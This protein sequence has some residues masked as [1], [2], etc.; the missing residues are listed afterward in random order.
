MTAVHASLCAPQVRSKTIPS[1][2][3]GVADFAKRGENAIPLG[4]SMSLDGVESV[5]ISA[6]LD[7]S[8]TSNCGI[9]GRSRNTQ[10]LSSQLH[11]LLN[12]VSRQ[13]SSPRYGSWDSSQL[14]F[15]KGEI[16]RPL[17]AVGLTLHLT[18]SLALSS[19]CHRYRLSCS[20]SSNRHAA[21]ITATAEGLPLDL[22]LVNVTLFDL[23][24]N[25]RSELGHLV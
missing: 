10:Q 4:Q 11:F 5:R 9:I 13:S 1:T 15:E 24:C 22:A 3:S 25:R 23:H 14:L 7:R 8:P 19:S 21:Y 17:T 2:D 16:I 12:V 6:R 18:M 20:D